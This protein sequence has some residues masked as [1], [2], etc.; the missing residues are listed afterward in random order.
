MGT[1]IQQSD[2]ARD[3]LYT[4]VNQIADEKVSLTDSQTIT[5]VKQFTQSISQQKSTFTKGTTPSSGLT[6]GIL[7]QD[8]EDLNKNSNRLGMVVNTVNTVGNVATYLSAYKNVA[9]STDYASI[10]IYYPANGDPYTAA[11][12][13]TDTTSTSSRQIATTGWVNTVGNNVVHLSGNETIAGTK[14]FSTSPVVPTPGTSDNSTKSAT[15]AYVNNKLVKVS[16][17]PA[18]PDSNVY[19]FIP[20]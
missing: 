19:Y 15:T 3:A 5:G 1:R 9:N 16:T 14:T 8:K 11:P 12:T 6:T 4:K 2:L 7:F 20:E 18:S 10:A 13:P 17:L